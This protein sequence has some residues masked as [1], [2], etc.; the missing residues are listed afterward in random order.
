MRIFYIIFLYIILSNFRRVNLLKLS[1]NQK[2]SRNVWV[3]FH[4]VK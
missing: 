3:I 4:N 2:L 1:K